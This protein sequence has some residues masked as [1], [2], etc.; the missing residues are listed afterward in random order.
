[1][2]NCAEENAWQTGRCFVVFSDVVQNDEYE[3][4]SH[5]RT[6]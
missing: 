3:M 1:M 6:G 2:V 4:I 5:D